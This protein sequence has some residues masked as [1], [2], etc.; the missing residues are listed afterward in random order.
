M[1][2]LCTFYLVVSI[3][4][5]LFDPFFISSTIITN[6]W[7]WYR[8]LIE[9]SQYSYLISTTNDLPSPETDTISFWKNFVAILTAFNIQFRIIAGFYIE[10]AVLICVL[11]LWAPVLGYI[12][13]IDGYIE[14][15]KCAEFA[16]S[17]SQDVAV[18][19][20]RNEFVVK[21]DENMVISQFKLLKCLSTL[22]CEAI[23]GVLVFSITEVAFGYAIDFEEAILTTDP[24]RRFI[25]VLFFVSTSSTFIFAAEIC[26]KVRN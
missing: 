7:S 9:E 4:R 21:I 10:L 15:K 8:R 5:L 24:M 18:A 16:S 13:T 17:Q 23:G 14:A 26:R 11:S 25:N 20:D 12:T 2:C 6:S 1:S 19:D 3:I 22:I